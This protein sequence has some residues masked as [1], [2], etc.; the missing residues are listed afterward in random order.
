[1]KSRILGFAIVPL[2]ALSNQAHAALEEVTFQAPQVFDQEA[3]APPPNSISGYFFFDTSQVTGG[4]RPVSQVPGA[5][6]G[7]A[8]TAVVF[9]GAG[10]SGAETLT[11]NDGS[12]LTVPLTTG[13]SLSGD[14]QVPRCGFFDNCQYTVGQVLTLDQFNAAPDPWALVTNGMTGASNGFFPLD[15]TF[16]LQGSSQF[17]VRSVPE[18]T[19]LSLL[20]LGL[21][22]VMVRALRRRRHAVQACRTS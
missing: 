9:F 2:L 16:Q 10:P 1:M 3:P 19:T 7:A 22:G 21:F 17:Q 8:G 14:F 13:F 12:V 20:G 18:P 5:P 11:L 6:P 15:F 4:L